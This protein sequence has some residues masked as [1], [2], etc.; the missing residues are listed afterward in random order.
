MKKEVRFKNGKTGEIE[1]LEV[2]IDDLGLPLQRLDIFGGNSL[3]KIAKTF[4]IEI[5][6]GNQDKI[7]ARWDEIQKNHRDKLIYLE[8]KELN[9]KDKPK[10]EWFMPNTTQVPNSLWDDLPHMSNSELRLILIVIRQT[11]GWEE[12]KK[13]GRRK[14]RDWISGTQ[15][16][17]KSGLSNKTITRA[18]KSDYFNKWVEMLDEDNNLLDTPERRR[19][20]GQVHKKFFYRLKIGLRTNSP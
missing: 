3:H 16:E 11:I 20:A 8:A 15:L 9:N 14:E 13:T 1:T 5:W 7:S 12:D 17:V 10:N 2:Q 18:R 19:A 6:E 4:S